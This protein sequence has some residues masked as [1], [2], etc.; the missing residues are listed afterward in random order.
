VNI[1]QALKLSDGSPLIKISRLRLADEVP[2]LYE[3]VYLPLDR[4]QGLEH[5]EWAPDDS[6]YR[7]LRE[8]Y[9]VLV[10]GLDHTIKPTLL[11]REQAK[12][13]GV[14]AG[15]PALISEIVSYSMEGNPVEYSLSVSNGDKGEFYFR[16]R[17]IE[18]DG[19]P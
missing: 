16:F 10:S 7:L 12:C 5:H 14:K 1:S 4:F 3:V 9:G 17:H 8:K 13:F 19:E 15:L 11:T 2:I 6:L 18:A